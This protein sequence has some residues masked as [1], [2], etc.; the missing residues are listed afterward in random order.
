MSDIATDAAT[1]ATA[2]GAT[3]TD[4][5]T[6]TAGQTE[7]KC[8]FEQKQITS[9]KYAEVY[10]G[11]IVSLHEHFMPIGVFRQLFASDRQADFVDIAPAEKAAGFTA[12]IGDIVTY[13]DGTL[14][15]TRP[16]YPDTL[17]GWKN[18]RLDE[19]NI[20]IGNLIV[21]G[22]TSS[23]TGVAVKYDSD[24]ETQLTMGNI[25]T[26]IITQEDKFNINYPQ[27]CP[28]RGYVGDATVKSVLYLT[29]EQFYSWISDMNLHIGHC[30]ELGWQ[31]QAEINACTTID[32]VKAVTW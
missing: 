7:F 31:K 25:S 2:A 14:T 12:A 21:S 16:V 11:R 6:N 20:Y 27:G 13:N 9:Y 8:V 23:C 32:S 5:Q 10:Q 4:A 28:V 19:L 17:E 29:K 15:I 3:S 30:K 24:E 26:S 22:F 1:A 18:R